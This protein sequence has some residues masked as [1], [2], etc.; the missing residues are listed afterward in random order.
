MEFRKTDPGSALMFRI[1]LM[2]FALVTSA[3]LM[4]QGPPAE[5]APTQTPQGG[6][7]GRRQG[8]LGQGTA[9]NITAITGDTITLKT[10][11][12]TETVKT[13]ADTMYRRDREAAKLSDFKVGDTVFVMGDKSGEAWTARMVAKRT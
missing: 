9:G 13:T 6:Q 12:G 1:R 3:A 7:G 10:I 4:A 5:G 2:L 8:T 11:S